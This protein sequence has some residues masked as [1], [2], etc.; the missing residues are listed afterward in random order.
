MDF[1]RRGALAALTG[2]ATLLAGCGPA[3]RPSN[4]TDVTLR[5]GV[6]RLTRRLLEASGQLPTPYKLAQQEFASGNLV[7]EAIGASALDLGG[8]SDIPPIF[9]A[10]TGSPLRLI[11]IR[12]GDVNSQVVLVQKNSGIDRPADLRGKRVGYTRATTAHYFLLKLLK[13]NGL[14][15]AD[16][17]PVALTPQDGRAAFETGRLDAWINWP[18]LAQL[19]QAATGARVLLGA[20]G[21]LSGNYVVAAHKDAIA[22]PHRHAAITDYLLREKRAYQWSLAN[23]GKYAAI[24]A[25]ELNAPAEIFLAIEKNRSQPTRLTAIDDGAIAAQQAVA[26][27]FAEAG[28]I[29]ARVDVRPLW[30]RSF[31][32]AL[33]AA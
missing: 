16:I 4:L 18:P 29:P 32:A 24:Q 9:V 25:R 8:M 10:G 13:D 15:F 5:V 14:T 21:Y 3:N 27:T 22:D 33:G 12:R 23:P 26:D 2:G 19:A 1:T 28:L 7:T 30:D 17:Q 11:A 20:Q 6:N 31:D